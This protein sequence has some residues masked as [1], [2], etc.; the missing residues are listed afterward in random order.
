[1]GFPEFT[2][3]AS[4]GADERVEFLALLWVFGDFFFR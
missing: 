2:A 4:G 3:L 1:M